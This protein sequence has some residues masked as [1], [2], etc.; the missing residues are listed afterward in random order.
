MP[1]PPTKREHRHHAFDLLAGT[2]NRDRHLLMPLRTHSASNVSLG[3]P[4][5]V[6]RGRLV[7]GGLALEPSAGAIQ[8]LDFLGDRCRAAAGGAPSRAFRPH[9]RCRRG[10]TGRVAARVG[11]PGRSRV[12]S[13][14]SSPRVVLGQP[15]GVATGLGPVPAVAAGRAG[16][17]CAG[18][19][20]ALAAAGSGRPPAQ[21]WP[22]AL[23]P[24]ARLRVRLRWAPAPPARS[25]PASAASVFRRY[26]RSAWSRAIRARPWAAASLRAATDAAAAPGFR[27][28]RL[29]ARGWKS[30]G[31]SIARCGTSRARACSGSGTSTAWT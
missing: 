30:S 26:A 1:Q 31:V 28:R 10:C 19:C 13:P 14:Q 9:A 22:W 12:L 24:R 25:V 3:A 11:P 29:R 6:E 2:G 17:G 23:V 21:W 16:A 4:V 18:A 27:A 15:P 7:G 8:V 5:L 20:C